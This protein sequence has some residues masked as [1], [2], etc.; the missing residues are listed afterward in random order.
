MDDQIS[1]ISKQC[2]YQLRN[3]GRI[4]KY[5]TESACKTLVCS[6]VTS[7]LDYGNVLLYGLS[8]GSL[9]RLQRIQ[10]TAARI[11]T[12][13]KK[14]DHITP[15]L[16]SLHWL[17]VEFRIQYKILITVFKALQGMSPLYIED[18]VNLYFPARSL[19]SQN[20]RCLVQPR[21]RTKSY[22]NRHFDVSATALWNSLSS[23]MRHGQNLNS[24]K[25]V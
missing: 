25:S 4:R 12:R 5:I 17:P 15:V 19:R 2:F 3:I 24:F 21:A 13:T 7:R 23:V 8:S 9:S 14:Q 6:L 1:S 11:I 18:L 10:N 22:G 20:S 16:I